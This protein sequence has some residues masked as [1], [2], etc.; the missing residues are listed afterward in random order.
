M[1]GT[2]RDATR[3][4]RAY[5]DHLTADDLRLLARTEDPQSLR[6]RPA[7][8]VALLDQPDVF[9]AIYPRHGQPSGSFLFV[10]PFLAFAV[11][12]HRVAAELPRSQYV[13]ERDHLGHRLPVFDVPLLAAFLDLPQRL[14]LAEL[15]ASY[16]H[17][18]SGSYWTRTPRGWRRRRWSELDPVRLAGLL[19]AVPQTERAGVYRRLGD[20]ALF[21]TGVFPDHAARHGLPPVQAGRLLATLAVRDAERAAGGTLELL[22]W[23]G[24]RWYRQAAAT[25]LWPS[26]QTRMV[27]LVAESFDEARRVLNVVADRYLFPVGNP[28]FP[29]PWQ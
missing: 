7:E 9:E 22:Q 18:A 21:L 11:A 27:A 8:V 15:L 12:L 2:D 5:L 1:D 23:L 3:V 29:T 26:D 19:E 24:V 4:G 13:V 25:A 6:A 28:W 17:V 16:A 10:S 20:L 14:F